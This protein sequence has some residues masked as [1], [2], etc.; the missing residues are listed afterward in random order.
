[1][2]LQDK[3]DWLLHVDTDE[4]IFPAGSPAFSLQV[5]RSRDPSKAH[6][7]VKNRLVVPYLCMLGSKAKCVGRGFAGCAGGVGRGAC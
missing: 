7:V 2:A 1:M 3:V 5:R 4:L 6:A